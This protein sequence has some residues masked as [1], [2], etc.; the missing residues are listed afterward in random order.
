ML[1][2]DADQVRANEGLYAAS[3]FGNICLPTDGS[4]L[5]MKAVRS[6]IRL[7]REQKARITAYY[8]CAA[9][10][11]TVYPSAYGAAL[12]SPAEHALAEKRRSDH[13]LTAVCKAARA[14]GVPC[15]RMRTIGERPGEEIVKAARKSGCDLICIASHGRRGISRLLLGSETARVLALSRMPVLVVH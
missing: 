14:V 7:A 2:I 1:M 12:V 11:S 15:T 10:H 6:G 5:S 3:M 9:W 4:A 13:C 8:M